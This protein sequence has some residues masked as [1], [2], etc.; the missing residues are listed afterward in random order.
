M[1][2]IA[3][4]QPAG[5]GILKINLSAQVS[6]YPDHVDFLVRVKNLGTVSA[7]R[8]SVELQSADISTTSGPEK[9]LLPQ[10]TFQH[11]FSLRFAGKKSG[12]YPYAIRCR[13]VDANGQPL[14]AVLASTYV[15]GRKGDGLPL[16]LAFS[17]IDIRRS[18]SIHC[19]LENLSDTNQV[20]TQRFVL[21][22]GF[23]VKPVQRRINLRPHEKQRLR[24]EL[25]NNTSAPD[26]TY[27]FYSILSADH[28]V[29]RRALVRES[30]IHV[31]ASLNEN[32][33]YKTRWRWFFGYFLALAIIVLYGLAG[34]G[35][36][37]R[38][39]NLSVN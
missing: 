21:P 39:G 37:K 23:S 35:R 9:R 22:D 27:P 5:A 15:F 2:V 32:R 1:G 36:R 11:V 12:T 29:Y 19:E 38:K 34:P 30:S 16:R 24:Y 7:H 33:W 18:G 13:Y 25:L 8:I 10:H 28:P 4:A 26:A 17:E 6:T 31:S 20:L 3:F 14:S